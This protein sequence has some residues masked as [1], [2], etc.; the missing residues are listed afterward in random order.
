[1]LVTA[2]AEQAA[3]ESGLRF[4]LGFLRLFSSSIGFSGFFS[5]IGL[6]LFD[7]LIIRR[8][9]LVAASTKEA[10][11]E[12]GFLFLLCLLLFLNGRR[13]FSR[14]VSCLGFALLLV[15][16][17]QKEEAAQQA[18]LRLCVIRR[19]CFGGA[20]FRLGPGRRIRSG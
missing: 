2:G 11:Q 12:A 4:F 19:R 13:S 9:F 20:V 7:A 16:I 1:L 8:L 14:F 17:P 6:S 10:A 15:R 5:K 3:H 18:A